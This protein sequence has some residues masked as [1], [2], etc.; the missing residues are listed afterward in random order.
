MWAER[1]GAG[2]T[3]KRA[4]AAFAGGGVAMFGARLADG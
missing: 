3:A 1:F 4:A 2:S